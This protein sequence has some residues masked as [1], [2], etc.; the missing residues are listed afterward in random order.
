MV[1]PEL[2]ETD[3][4]AESVLFNYQVGSKSGPAKAGPAGPAAPPLVHV[5]P[6]SRR[7]LSLFLY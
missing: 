1:G 2:R 3:A 6:H 4:I 5:L 7:A